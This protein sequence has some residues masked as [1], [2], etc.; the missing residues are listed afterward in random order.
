MIHG[1]VFLYTCII[2]SLNLVSAVSKIPL[3]IGTQSYIT[4][5]GNFRENILKLF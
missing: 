2:F 3:P 4:M 5:A 1:D